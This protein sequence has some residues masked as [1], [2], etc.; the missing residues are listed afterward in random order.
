MVVYLSWSVKQTIDRAK[1]TVAV[2]VMRRIRLVSLGRSCEISLTA[3]YIKIASHYFQI[4]SGLKYFT[5]PSFLGLDLIVDKIG[6]SFSKTAF[7]LDCFLFENLTSVLPLNFLRVIWLHVNTVVCIL[8]FF[9]VYKLLTFCKRITPKSYIMSNAFILFSL[10][11][12]Y[13]I[14]SVLISS[15]SCRSIDSKEYVR[16]FLEMECWSEEHIQ[17]TLYLILPLLLL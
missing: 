16:Y 14:M 10:F 8:I 12:Q 4:V 1:S 15:L 7:S 11:T 2:N 3:A 6:D 13:S 17:L 5:V 9:V